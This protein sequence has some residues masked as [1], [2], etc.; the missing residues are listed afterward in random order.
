MPEM[1]GI[2]AAKNI[3]NLV[4]D[5]GM[6][7]VKDFCNIVALT[8]YSSEKVKKDVIAVGMKELLSKPIDV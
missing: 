8:A 5:A 2:D 4:K 3:L 6:A 7:N 1:N